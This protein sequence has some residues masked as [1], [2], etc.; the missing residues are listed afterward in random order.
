M[1]Y[2]RFNQVVYETQVTDENGRIRASYT[3]SAMDNDRNFVV[4]IV[5]SIDEE[6]VEGVSNFIVT[7]QPTARVHGVVY[8][9]TT[10]E[11]ASNI[12]V[13]WAQ[14][15]LHVHRELSFTDSNG[16][17]DAYVPI[18]SKTAFIGIDFEE[19]ILNVTNLH[20]SSL[21]YIDPNTNRFSMEIMADTNYEIN[22]DHGIVI[23]RTRNNAEIYVMRYVNGVRDDKEG[24]AFDALS[25]GTF[26][27][28]LQAGVYDFV[29]MRSAAYLVRNVTANKGETVD[30]GTI[31]R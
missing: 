16:R 14:R 17:Y 4:K 6:Y 27:I 24:I 15:D 18:R 1:E 25:D 11:P 7:N 23:G 26:V 20:R 8:Y 2:G 19:N 3:T 5:T 13:M 12:R 21:S 28:P 30:L 22:F 29:H 9:P 10:G 31:D